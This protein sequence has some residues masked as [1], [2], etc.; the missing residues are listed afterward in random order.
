MR[1]KT[2]SL[3]LDSLDGLD[4]GLDIVG[5]GLEGGE[6][7]LDLINDGLVLEDLAVVSEINGSLLLLEISQDAAS[8]LVALAE[9]AQ[10]GNGLGL[11]TEG[12]GQLGPVD[13]SSGSLNSGHDDGDVGLSGER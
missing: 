5:G 13:V 8:L 7:L 6:S 3:G 2:Y 1:W 11:E 12:G 9:G 10:S 4:L